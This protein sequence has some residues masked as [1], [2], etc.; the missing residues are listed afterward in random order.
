M[1]PTIWILLLDYE[2]I[3]Q[4][5]KRPFNIV[6]NHIIHF[7]FIN[8]IILWSM[9]IP[10]GSTHLLNHRGQFFIHASLALMNPSIFIT[11]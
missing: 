4:I 2:A 6:G 7:I 1:D 8:T 9:R 5:T 11:L 10:H 3:S